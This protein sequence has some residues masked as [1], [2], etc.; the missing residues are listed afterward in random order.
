[1]ATTSNVRKLH[2]DQLLSDW[3]CLFKVN[4]WILGKEEKK[5]LPFVSAFSFAQERLFVLWSY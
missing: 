1:M 5:S 2:M 4:N 3:Y